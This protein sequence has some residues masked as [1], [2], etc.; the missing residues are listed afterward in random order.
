MAMTE[1]QPT[2]TLDYLLQHIVALMDTQSDQVLQE[3]LGLTLAQYK[4]LR[5][6]GPDK[7]VSQKQLA[8]MLGQTEASVSRQI[9]LMTGRGITQ[10]LRDPRDKRGH[11]AAVT[12]KGEQ[13]LAAATQVLDTYYAPTLAALPKK[14]AKQLCEGLHALHGALCVTGHDTAGTL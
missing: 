4:I 1:M 11:P 12:P 5:L 2:G 8:R 10:S 7:H 3:Q 9:R 14:Q 6:L 13:L